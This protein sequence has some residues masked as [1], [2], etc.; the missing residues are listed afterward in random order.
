[1]K[2][3]LFVFAFLWIVSSDVHAQS[4]GL[5]TSFEMEEGKQYIPENVGSFVGAMT[6]CYNNY[7]GQS[8]LEIYRSTIPIINQ[9]IPVDRNVAMGKYAEVVRR[10]IFASQKLTRAECERLINS[11]WMDFL[12]QSN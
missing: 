4:D 10:R 12:N 6:S 1:M 8:Y 11:N 5:N 7:K 3:I 2:L 9:M